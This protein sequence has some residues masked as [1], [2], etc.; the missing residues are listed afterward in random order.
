MRELEERAATRHVVV[1]K[2]KGFEAGT[3]LEHP[4]S[5][6]VALDFV[7][8]QVAR[9]VQRARRHLQ[10]GGGCLLCAVVEEERRGGERIVF[11]REGFVAFAPFA[12][13]SAGEVL[14]VPEAHA[15]SFTT[16]SSEDRDRLA[17]RLIDL[18]R[19]MRDAFDDPA[20]NLVLHTAPRRWRDDEALHWYWQLVPRLTR[21]AGLELATGLNINQ[22]PPEDAARL[23][24]ATQT[25]VEGS[26]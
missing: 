3:S 25:A 4:H 10:S 18:L 24:R 13:G 21:Q 26:A 2:N 22:M 15:P 19:R 12:S 9:R 17:L 8:R 1:F 14:L 16:T 20:Y 11:E 6:V 23:L 7:P 5:Q